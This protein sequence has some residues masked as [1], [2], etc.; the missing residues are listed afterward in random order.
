M[1]ISLN[2]YNWRSQRFHKEIEP[3]TQ[4]FRINGLKKRREEYNT[5][6]PLG[7]TEKYFRWLK[8]CW[9]LASRRVQSSF[10]WKKEMML[11]FEWKSDPGKAEF[12]FNELSY[13]EQNIL[14]E[15]Q[16]AWYHIKSRKMQIGIPG[17]ILV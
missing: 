3:K 7:I 5:G 15:R 12:K 8:F 14:E 17:F 16:A 2:H 1:Q 11:V 4:T 9:I 6:Q 10:S 13:T